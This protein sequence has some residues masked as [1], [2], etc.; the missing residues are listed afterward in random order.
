M[1]CKPHPTGGYRAYKKINGKEHQYY[2][3]SK[4]EAEKKQKEFDALASLKPK[5]VFDISGRL[6]GCK[7][8]RH[9]NGG[10]NMNIQLKG[11]HKSKSLGAYKFETVWGWTKEH[12]KHHHQL[13]PADIAD[14]TKELKRAK[15]IYL[16]DLSK[17]L[18]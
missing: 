5:R 17:L 10:I 11:L 4:Q 2:S 12:W 3:R 18:K 9:H 1:A 7:I 14:Y 13:T 8:F 16:N 6:V 15:R